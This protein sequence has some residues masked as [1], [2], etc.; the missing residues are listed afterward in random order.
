MKWLHTVL[1]FAAWTSVIFLFG[2]R[3]SYAQSEPS[4]QV[5]FDDNGLSSLRFGGT[6]MLHPGPMDLPRLDLRHGYPPDRV[7]AP[8]GTPQAS[9]DSAAY[10]LSQA[11][12]WGTLSCTYRAEGNRL[13]L[14]LEVIN[15]TSK[16]SIFGFTA[17]PL[18]LQ[19][20]GAVKTKG[21][22]HDWPSPS[23]LN[24]A[25]QILNVS[26]PDGVMAICN[27][28]VDC[29]L[30]LNL[31]RVEHSDRYKVVVRLDGPPRG[32]GIGGGDSR[33]YHL[34]I[35]F[36]S[37]GASSLEL[38]QDINQRFAERYPSE[39]KW[40]DRRPIG[41]CFCSSQDFRSPTNPSG[42]LHDTKVDMTT[43]AGR[44]DWKRRMLAQGDKS[45][46]VAKE[47]GC[48]GVIVWDIEGQRNTQ[49]ISYIGDP[50]LMPTLSPEMDA[51]A[52]VL[53]KKY[54][55]AGLRCGVTL[56]PTHV[57][58][59]SGGKE[60]W[61]HVDVEDIVAELAG[62]LDY[63]SKRWGCTLFYVDSTV[64]CDLNADGL[65]ELHTLPAEIFQSLH[66]QFPDVLLIPEES[67]TR[68]HAYTAPYHE[69]MPPHNYTITPPEVR[70]VYPNAF[71]VIRVADTPVI[72]SDFDAIVAAVR[73]GDII[74]FRTWLDDPDNVPVKRILERVG[75]Q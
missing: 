65:F 55:D 45:V 30:W 56:R 24:D 18:Q 44:A 16:D 39:L 53:F 2:N 22:A 69:I 71:S 64:R 61:E 63:A 26:W 6:E 34:S 46:A 7:L 72:Q 27:E 32:Q 42:W 36:G 40:D 74:M 5:R 1:T 47:M 31:E 54:T 25:P 41:C 67:S 33:Q 12:S 29:P 49:P 62:K 59:T 3:A 13:L 50:R 38:A 9:F 17:V 66:R 48:Q 28:Q 20:S 58:R 52:D 14:D 68:H 43:E 57:V 8:T 70:A 75:R 35:R 51:I 10:R 15:T 23:V 60:A 21:W 19:L 37:V 11:Y 73:S 4:L